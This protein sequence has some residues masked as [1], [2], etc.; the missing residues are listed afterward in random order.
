[1][2]ILKKIF[3]KAIKDKA[4]FIYKFANYDLN[5]FQ[6]KHAESLK[7][8]EFLS[9]LSTLSLFSNF[10]DEFEQLFDKLDTKGLGCVNFNDFCSYLMI[11]YKEK[12]FYESLK[13]IPFNNALN[14]KHSLH[15]KVFMN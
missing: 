7:K 15:N 14:V 11:K 6:K 8:E 1:M 9:A 13:A 10:K 4:D 12:E 3:I 5:D 2:N